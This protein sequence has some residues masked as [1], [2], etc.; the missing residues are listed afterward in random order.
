MFA[1]WRYL[2]ANWTLSCCKIFAEENF[3]KSSLLM[4]A[5]LLLEIPATLWGCCWVSHYIQSLSGSLYSTLQITNNVIH[6]WW[7]LDTC[8]LK[9]IKKK[10]HSACDV[11]SRFLLPKQ[12]SP[13]RDIYCSER[14]GLVKY[15][16]VERNSVFRVSD[17]E[18]LF[19]AVHGPIWLCN[20][21]QR[22]C[23][24]CLEAWAP[25]LLCNKKPKFSWFMIN[26]ILW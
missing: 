26:E 15:K 6:H 20:A 14:K 10:C 5:K 2:E 16:R 9:Q 17:A 25:L 4:N 11:K 18:M 21:N 8:Y 13:C 3:S 23:P 7:E 19:M 24:K 22:Q 12:R 1:G